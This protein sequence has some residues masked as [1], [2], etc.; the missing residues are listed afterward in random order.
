MC[1]ML[2]IIIN[3]MLQIIRYSNKWTKNEKGNHL[4]NV[5]IHDTSLCSLLKLHEYFMCY[6][7]YFIFL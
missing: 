2:E 1:T 7:L 6:V 3:T 5:D 4:H